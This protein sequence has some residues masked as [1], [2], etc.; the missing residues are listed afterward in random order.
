MALSTT[1]I[2]KRFQGPIN[3][4]SGTTTTWFVGSAS[5]RYLIKNIRIVNNSAGAITIKI[6]IGGVTDPLL[7]L[8][9]LTLAAGDTYNDDCFFCLEGAE[10]IQ[11]NASATGLTMTISGLNQV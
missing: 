1:E 9:A 5:N 6:G 8:P 2:L 7:I 4:P 3:V 11:T 10:S